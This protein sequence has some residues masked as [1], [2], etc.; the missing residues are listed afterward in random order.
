MISNNHHLAPIEGEDYQ[1]FEKDLP[2]GNTTGFSP[3]QKISDR[4]PLETCETI[5]DSWGYRMADEHYKSTEDLIRLLVRAAGYGANLLLNVGPM[6]NGE[7]QDECVVRL[8]E[9]GKWTS[10]YGETIYGTQAGIV[11]PQSWG[12]ATQKGSKHYI[13]ILGKDEER[14]VVRFP[15]KIKSARWL[16]ID[17][18]LIWKRDNKTGDV[19]FELTGVPLDEVDSIIEVDI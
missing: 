16:N 9:V 5:N 14:V 7:I 6:P 3:D 12:A 1:A 2:G 8:A 4:L 10:A 11:K 18:K 17:S 19:T 15:Q 13:H